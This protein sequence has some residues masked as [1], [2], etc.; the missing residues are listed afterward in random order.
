MI[1]CIQVYN[2]K[3]A[4]VLKFIKVTRAD[5]KERERDNVSQPNPVG[6]SLLIETMK[7]HML[8]RDEVVTCVSVASLVYACREFL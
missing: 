3:S 8:M 5:L 4:N 7:I 1:T 6:V 2:R